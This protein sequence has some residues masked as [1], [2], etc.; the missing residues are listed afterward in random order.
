MS[1]RLSVEYCFVL[2]V[3]TGNR[4]ELLSSA[5]G[6]FLFGIDCGAVVKESG[7]RFMEIASTLLLHG[8]QL[9]LLQIVCI[10]EDT[11]R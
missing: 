9:K 1:F 4:S 7:Q 5:L 11:H 10:K 6:N 8:P 2:V 3:V